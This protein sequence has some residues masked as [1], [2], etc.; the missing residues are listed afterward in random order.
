MA[1]TAHQLFEHHLREM[2]DAEQKMERAL[3]RMASKATNRQLAKGFNTHARTTA[4]QAKRLEQVFKAVG[5]K[6]RR[7]TCAGM[8]GLIE[9]YSTFV[10]EERPDDAVLDAFSAEAGLKAEH[11]EIV[12]YKSLIDLAK[13]LGFKDEAAILKET[14]REEEATAAELETLSK[15]LAK[16]MPM[17]GEDNE[18]SESSWTE[19]LQ[20]TVGSRT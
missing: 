9:E 14:L 5:K 6:A 12:A 11:Y 19:T 20:R 3:K 10:R 15:T 17:D 16:A 7:Q 2:Y 8:D 1:D 18:D 13:Q 4:R